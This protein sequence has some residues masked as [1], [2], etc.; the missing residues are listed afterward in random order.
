MGNLCECPDPKHLI[1]SEVNFNSNVLSTVNEEENEYAEENKSLLKSKDYA[2]KKDKSL[3]FNAFKNYSQ[4]TSLQKSLNVSNRRTRK[5]LLY[6]KLQVQENSGYSYN[7]YTNLKSIE[8]TNASINESKDIDYRYQSERIFSSLNELRSNPKRIIHQIDSILQNKDSNKDIL[9]LLTYS[10]LSS[11]LQE[12]VNFNSNDVSFAQNNVIDNLL[13]IKKRLTLGL[14]EGKFHPSPILWSEKMYSNINEYLSS[15]STLV[16]KLFSSQSIRKS[17]LKIIEDYLSKDN[18]IKLYTLSGN[19]DIDTIVLLYLYQNLDYLDEIIFDKKDQGVV[20]SLSLNEKI[21]NLIVLIRKKHTSSNSILKMK[22]NSASLSNLQNIN[23]TTN[24]TN[25][26][27]NNN[28]TNNSIFNQINHNSNYIEIQM[29]IDNKLFDSI[30]YKDQII[31][32]RYYKYA[33]S[34]N[35]IFAIFVLENGDVKNEMFRL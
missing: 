28:N 31:D 11:I 2:D 33:D 19:H 29:S 21:I 7:P 26:Q 16:N 35:N 30:L 6:D 18:I 15:N 9:N 17:T 20:V 24:E 4:C 14:T 10:F 32:S 34:A 23:E 3:T 5:T 27:Q 1:N 8:L 13:L 22:N 25:Y 12:S